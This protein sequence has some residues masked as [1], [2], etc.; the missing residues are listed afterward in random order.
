MKRTFNEEHIDA[1]AAAMHDEKF[2]GARDHELWDTPSHRE[3][4]WFAACRN[5]YLSTARLA[6]GAVNG[7]VEVIDEPEWMKIPEG[8]ANAVVAA[9]NKVVGTYWRDMRRGHLM[10]V[11]PLTDNADAVRFDFVETVELVEVLRPSDVAVPREVVER[12]VKVRDDEFASITD[13]AEVVH[14]LADVLSPKAG[15]R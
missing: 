14:L 10:M 6:L 15:G 9:V 3:G 13:N 4:G 12:A 5:E 8:S 11:D 2:K 7:T 1:A